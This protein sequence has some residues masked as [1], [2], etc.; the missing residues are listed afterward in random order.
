MRTSASSPSG[1]LVVGFGGLWLVAHA[2]HL[3]PWIVRSG[4]WCTR[5]AYVQPMCVWVYEGCIHAREVIIRYVSAPSSAL[6]LASAI[7]KQRHLKHAT[8]SLSDMVSSCA[9]CRGWGHTW[10]GHF[11]PSDRVGHWSDRHG[12]PGAPQASAACSQHL[13]LLG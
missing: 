2:W 12:K 11:L 7:H 9:L 8:C 3:M 5:P 1:E 4:L 13:H 6:H 10:P